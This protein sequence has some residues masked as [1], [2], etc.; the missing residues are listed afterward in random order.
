MDGAEGRREREGGREGQDKGIR[1]GAKRGRESELHPT[2][3]KIPSL[4]TRALCR[5]FSVTVNTNQ[6]SDDQ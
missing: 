1:E 5:S 2:M 3:N 6:M 4:S